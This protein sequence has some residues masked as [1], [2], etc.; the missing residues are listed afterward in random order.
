MIIDNIQKYYSQLTYS[1]VPISTHVLRVGEEEVFLP[2]LIDGEAVL[3]FTIER[4][5]F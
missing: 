5:L 1:L 2:G 4:H 3:V